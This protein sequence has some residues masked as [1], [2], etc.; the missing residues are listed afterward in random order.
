MALPSLSL[1]KSLPVTASGSVPLY[2]PSSPSNLHFP[3]K[4]I[5]KIPHKF[6]I[7][8]QSTRIT[9]ETRVSF[10]PAF[11]TQK[12]DA[13]SIKEELLQAIEPLDRGADATP[14]D[15]QRIDQVGPLLFR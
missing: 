1:S 9:T 15:Q 14:E 4:S 13:K 12:R 10:F 11:L 3:S 8:K 5:H 7:S 6:L 2:L